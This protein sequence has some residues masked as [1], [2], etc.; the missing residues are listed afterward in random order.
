MDGLPS[1]CFYQSLRR[2]CR[3]SGL[4]GSRCSIFFSSFEAPPSDQSAQLL[5]SYPAWFSPCRY[6]FLFEGVQVLNA[7]FPRGQYRG[8]VVFCLASRQSAQ[9]ASRSIP[10]VGLASPCSAP[11]FL[12]DHHSPNFIP[13]LSKNT[14][15]FSL[16]PSTTTSARP[17]D[18][19]TTSCQTDTAT[20]VVA[21]LEHGRISRQTREEYIR[22]CHRLRKKRGGGGAWGRYRNMSGTIKKRTWL[23]RM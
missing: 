14:S 7:T 1:L 15:F 9:H 8:L 3:Q 11:V 18:R 2:V 23:P 16:P 19:R 17:A 4:E 20:A 13:L 5:L 12:S 21:A 6:Y 22:I 10:S